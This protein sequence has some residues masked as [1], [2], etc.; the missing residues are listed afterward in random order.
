M[1]RNLSPGAVVI[2]DAL[3]SYPLA[4]AD[5]FGYKPFN[6]KRSG[7]PAH[8]LL[9]GAYRVASLA[10]GSLDRPWRAEDP[11]DLLPSSG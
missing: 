9:P 4:I 10:S 3:Q 8:E 6:I 11:S 2:N 1:L 7:L 5:T